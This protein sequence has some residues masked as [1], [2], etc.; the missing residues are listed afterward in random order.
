[1]TAKLPKINT[2]NDDM[3]DDLLGDYA[4]LGG[5]ASSKSSFIDINHKKQL[6]T[7]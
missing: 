1:M 3:T 7:H 2:L 4:D 6:L 5:I